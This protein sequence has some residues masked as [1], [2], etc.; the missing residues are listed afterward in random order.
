LAKEGNQ[1]KKDIK[2]EIFVPS[3]PPKKKKKAKKAA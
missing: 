1:E 2:I 3:K